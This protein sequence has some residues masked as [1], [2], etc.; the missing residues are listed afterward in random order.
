MSE[1][2]DRGIL[3]WAP[4]DAL[5]G[6]STVLE[7]MIYNIN[8]RQKQIISPDD[9]LEMD[10]TAKTAFEENKNVSLDYFRDGYTYSTYGK[11]KKIDQI[12]RFL[13]MDTNE[14]IP[15]DDVMMIR[16]V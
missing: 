10:Q 6:H 1:Y 12:N 8:K 2:K 4:F 15:F 9:Y 14:T 5:N 13:V 7:E 11:I 16:L 3:K